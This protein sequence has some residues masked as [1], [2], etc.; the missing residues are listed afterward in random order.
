M[1][2]EKRKQF[3]VE[4]RKVIEIS[5]ASFNEESRSTVQETIWIAITVCIRVMIKIYELYIVT[6][7]ILIKDYIQSE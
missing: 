2:D 1:D 3:V 5:L 4:R 6:E 7:R